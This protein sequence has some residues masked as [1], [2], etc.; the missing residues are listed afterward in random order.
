MI[1]IQTS[2]TKQIFEKGD[3]RKGN[4]EEKTKRFH[5]RYAGMSAGM[6]AGIA[7]AGGGTD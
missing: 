6:P 3:G 7:G 2:A 5:R 4:Y 1:K